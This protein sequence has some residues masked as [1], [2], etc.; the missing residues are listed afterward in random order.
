MLVPNMA[1]VVSSGVSPGDGQSVWVGRLRDNRTARGPWRRLGGSR[2]VRRSRDWAFPG[3]DS[4]GRPPARPRLVA[5][6]RTEWP[7]ARGKQKPRTSQRPGAQIALG[8]GQPPLRLTP[9]LTMLVTARRALCRTTDCLL[10]VIAR[11]AKPASAP[12]CLGSSQTA[13][14]TCITSA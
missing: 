5:P 14:A 12:Y 11:I 13:P 1:V 10:S 6:V 9:G 3:N 4:L 8:Q 2:C 7:R